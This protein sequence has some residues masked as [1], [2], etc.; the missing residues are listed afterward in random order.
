MI[1]STESGHT[2]HNTG[3]RKW[4]LR[5]LVSL[6]ATGSNRLKSFHTEGLGKVAIFRELLLLNSHSV[7]SNRDITLADF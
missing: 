6:S 7:V 4:T 5:C 3:P 2:S 1:G